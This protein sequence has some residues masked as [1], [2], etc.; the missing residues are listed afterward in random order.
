[1]LSP[2]AYVRAE[3][4]DDAIRHL[5][6]EGAV[7][8]AG[9]TDLLGCLRDHVFDVKKVVSISRLKSLTDIAK[10]KTGGMSIGAL[11]TVA[12]I[13]GNPLIRQL[14]TGL[15]R[16]ASEVASPQ[17]R[18][19]GT[20]GGNLCQKPR[21]WYYRGEFHCVRKGGDTCYAVDGENA[22]HCILG[23]SNCVIVHPSD[24]APAL[25]SLDARLHLQ[26]PKGKRT[27]P[28]DGFFLLPDLDPTRETVLSPG[29]IVTRIELP[30]PPPG[31]RSSYRKVRAR[32]SWDFALAGVALAL[33][34]DGDRVTKARVFLSG[35]AP[36]PWHARE[37]E[38][39][40][41]G[42]KLTPDVI[43]KAAEVAVQRAQPLEQNAY[44]IPLFRAVIEEE[45]QAMAQA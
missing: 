35:A 37:V 40:I 26:G 5:A 31:L 32:R 29:E 33:V 41:T 9:G 15:A 3:S 13:A 24:T 6:S 30:A 43:K 1:M 36:I 14:Y 19:Q 25:A 2:F 23:G 38:A 10:T 8:H 34:L 20:L 39:V 4:V 44:K 16:A 22:Y 7:A 45:L 12:E 42:H 11:A 17:L 21:C 27:V 18:N 28:V